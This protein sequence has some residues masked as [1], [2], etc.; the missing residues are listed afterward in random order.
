MYALGACVLLPKVD[1]WLV[2]HLKCPVLRVSW[3]A[4][5]DSASHE[6]NLT[7]SH[8]DEIEQ[9]I[10]V[11]DILRVR[12]CKIRLRDNNFRHSMVIALKNS[13]IMQSIT[14]P[15]ITF[16]WDLSAMKHAMVICARSA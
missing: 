8:E 14:F 15:R 12:S 2:H 6:V 5:K 3:R 13:W 11:Q 1:F 7:G 4:W 16:S 9:W 10:R